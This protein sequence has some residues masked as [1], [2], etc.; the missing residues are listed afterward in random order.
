[1]VAE[2]VVMAGGNNLS[3][4]LSSF[5]YLSLS[6]YIYLSFSVSKGEM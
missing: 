1:M 4:Y 5:M 6:F 3:L 2:K